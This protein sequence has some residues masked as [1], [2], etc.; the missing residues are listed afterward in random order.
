MNNYHAVVLVALLSPVLLTTSGDADEV[1]TDQIRQLKRAYVYVET[2]IERCKAYL[3]RTAGQTPQGTVA[4]ILDWKRRRDAA[5]DRWD[6]LDDV[7]D[8]L[9][10]RL[11]ALGVNV[12]QLKRQSDTAPPGIPAPPGKCTKCGGTGWLPCPHPDCVN[13]WYTNPA[14]DR[15]KC[16]VC[17][18]DDRV[19]CTRCGSLSQ[20]LNNSRGDGLE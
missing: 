1:P 5:S 12:A 7:R 19:T 3:T 10:R 9:A 18:G 13:G 17:N 6:R 11:K 2:E 15:R 4:Q 16:S 8:V 14:F 20:I